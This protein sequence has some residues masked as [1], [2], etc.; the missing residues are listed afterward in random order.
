MLRSPSHA[1]RPFAAMM[2]VVFLTGVRQLA[3][4]PQKVT[5]VE[6]ITEYRLDNGLQVLLFPDPSK[7]TVTVNITYLVGSRH[8]GLGEKGMAHLLEHMVFKGTQQFRN[9]WGALQD[10]G[11]NFNG[12]TWVDRTNYFE[13]L[14]ASDENLEFALRMEAD[15]MVNSRIAQEDLDSEMTVVRNEFEMGENDPVGVLSERMTS[16]AFLWHNYG[17]STIGNRSDIERVPVKNLRAFYK[18]YYQPDNAMLVVAGKFEADKALGLIEKYFG[19]LP[20]P[21]RTLDD[22]YTIEPIQDGERHVTLRRVGDI[23][24]AGA[25]YHMPAGSHP[26]FPAIEIAED[27]LTNEPSGRLYKGLVETGLAVNVRGSAYSF[28]EPGLFEVMAE[29]REDKDA[30]E[31]LNVMTSIIEGFGAT[32]ITSEEV[33]RAKTKMLKNIKL[34]STDSGRIGIELSEFAAM[35]DWRMFFIARDRLKTITPEDVKRVATEYFVS[36]NRTTGLFI[37][38]KEPVR[39]DIPETPDVAGIVKDYKGTETVD[40]GEAFV[41]TPENIESRTVRK[42]LPSGIKLALLSKETRGNA[43]S[44]MFRFHFGSEQS[45]TGHEEALDMVPAMLMRGTK[46]RTFQQIQDEIDRLQSRIN[47]GGGVGAAV[48]S[49]TSDSDNLYASIEL[50]GEILKEPSFPADEFDVI[51]KERLASLE[52]GLSEPGALAFNTFQRAMNPYPK[53]NI[54]YVDTIEEQ[55][56]KTKSLSLGDVRDVYGRFY[57]ASNVEVAVVGEFDEQKLVQ[58]IDK[59]FGSWKSPSPYKRVE[60]PHIAIQSLDKTIVTPDKANATVV[61]GARFPMR[62]DDPDYAALE[63]AN[64][65]LGSS[66]KSRVLTRLRHKGG[67]SY[68]ASTQLGVD[69][70]DNGASLAGFAICAPQN[71]AKAMDAMAEE[72]NNW[73]KDGITPDELADFREGYLKELENNFAQDRFIVG[74]LSR[75]LEI[76]RTMTYW[77]DLMARIKALN[78][79]QVN[80]AIKKHVGNV[81]MIKI[82][83]GD[84][85]EETA[86]AD[87]PPS[88][89]S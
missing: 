10:H 56:E 36:S 34:L 70:Q 60:D 23:Q 39:A 38:T 1:V 55:I 63:L 15:R 9:I 80:A 6:G 47:V 31:V 35:G 18:K 69:S 81:P 68:G 17:D 66:A 57:G 11:A 65:I 79:D 77:S 21:D 61:M 87:T 32:D 45:M 8:E 82:K 24:A 75:G 62:D 49:I 5:E 58:T 12:S 22:T 14:P 85:G 89:P 84:I 25:C 19:A 83:A 67:M 74:Q 33:E 48:A 16:T 28:A 50:V 41:A 88:D 72:I 76:E 37:P 73:M 2:V 44:A 78:A 30:Q 54:R 40:L 46:N 42:T 20:K 26:D 13:T 4:A 27:I 29:V 53:G 43:V 7:P 51:I 86:A 52:E 64:Y 71:A 59:V 3:A